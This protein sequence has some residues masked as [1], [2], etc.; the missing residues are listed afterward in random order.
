MHVA[1]TILAL[2]LWTL[3]L[4]D[5]ESLRATTDESL[6][7]HPEVTTQVAELQRERDPNRLFEALR[8]GSENVRRVAAGKL[9]TLDDDELKP[10]DVPTAVAALYH[11]D[12]VVRFL[13]ASALWR[14][15]LGP[16]GKPYVA[17][18]VQSLRDEEETVRKLAARILL[19][20]EPDESSV[21]A[22]RGVLEDENSDVRT[23]VVRLIG[24]MGRTGKRRYQIWSTRC[25]TR[26]MSCAKR[27]PG[28]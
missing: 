18:F 8:H 19:D 3:G 20:V 6:E 21:T 14:L 7:Q 13:A 9:A 11:E 17:D 15:Q 26:T 27:P 2:F 25:T 4:H 24:R 5:G 22:L 1:F 10:L 28:H 12:E 23:D 16:R